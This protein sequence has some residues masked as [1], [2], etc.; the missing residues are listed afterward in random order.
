MIQCHV[1][2][3]TF[4]KKCINKFVIKCNPFHIDLRTQT[5]RVYAGPRYGESISIKPKLCNKIYVFLV[6]VIVIHGHI[7]IAPVHDSSFDVREGV[8]DAGASTALAGSSFDLVSGGGDAEDEGGREVGAGEVVVELLLLLLLRHASEL[9]ARERERERV[10][11]TRSTTGREADFGLLRNRIERARALVV[12]PPCLFDCSV[13]SLLLLC[14]LLC[15]L[16]ASGFYIFCF[17]LA[18]SA[19][20]YGA[21]GS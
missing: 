18:W 12:P 19:R 8:P 5:I 21:I 14:S 3:D 9:R 13:V 20:V 10:G 7:P 15:S 17:L 1:W 16:F 4:F 11:E 6:A 2:L